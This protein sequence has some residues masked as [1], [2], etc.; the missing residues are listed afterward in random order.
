MQGFVEVETFIAPER[1]HYIGNKTQA[2][3]KQSGL[4]HHVTS[5]IHAA[6]VDKLQSME[7]KIYQ[8]NRN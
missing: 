1:T 3:R 4:K 5:T 2:N 8:N 6:M 7:S